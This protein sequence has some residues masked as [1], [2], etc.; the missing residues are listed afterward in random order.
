MAQKLKI[1][2]LSC[3]IEKRENVVLRVFQ[4]LVQAD[5]S[6]KLCTVLSELFLL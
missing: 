5:V 4:L 6:C 2:L 3:K 1:H